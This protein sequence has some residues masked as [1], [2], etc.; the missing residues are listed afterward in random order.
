MA[1]QPK[2][3]RGRRAR[4]SV[5]NRTPRPGVAE[6]PASSV[7]FSKRAT[8]Y[9][10]GLVYNV[11]AQ[12]EESIIPLGSIYWKD[13]IPDWDRFLRLSEA[14]QNAILRLFS[15]RYDLWAS[16][17][18]SADD[19]AY[20]G[21]ARRLFPRCPIF[22]RLKLTS[23]DEQAKEAVFKEAPKFFDAM[24]AGAQDVTISDSDGIMRVSAT[25]K[26]DNE[27]Q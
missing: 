3:S 20:W 22:Q 7:M 13:E 9:L 26:L 5:S 17:E 10:E 18:L 16:K 25:H 27:G 12:R 21:D 11:A 4:I 24:F 19:A 15:I 23:E 14:D 6:F 2:H 1:A 8:N